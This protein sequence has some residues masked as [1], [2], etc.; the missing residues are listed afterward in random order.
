MQS[1]VLALYLGGGL[2]RDL[3]PNRQPGLGLFV[4]RVSVPGRKEHSRLFARDLAPRVLVPYGRPMTC[5]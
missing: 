5:K 3:T 4:V 1:A 2:I